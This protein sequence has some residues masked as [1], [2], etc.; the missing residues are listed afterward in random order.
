MDLLVSKNSLFSLSAHL[1]GLGGTASLEAP[2]KK[3]SGRRLQMSGF[4]RAKR[5]LTLCGTQSWAGLPCHTR[6]PALGL[7]SV[8][9]GLE[10]PCLS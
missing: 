8:S 1:W 4:Q 9:L 10:R 5:D 7:P 2:E 3:A 6:G